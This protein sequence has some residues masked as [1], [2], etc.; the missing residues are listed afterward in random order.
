M[1]LSFE[2][3]VLNTHRTKQELK[4]KKEIPQINESIIKIAG[5]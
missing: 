2:H 3:T 4:K 5:D 1:F